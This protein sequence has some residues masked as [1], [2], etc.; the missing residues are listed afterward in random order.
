MNRA[1]VQTQSEVPSPCCRQ[2]KQSIQCDRREEPAWAHRLNGCP[3]SFPMDPTQQQKHRP[4][5]NDQA[6]QS[7]PA[8]RSLFGFHKRHSKSENPNLKVEKTPRGG[9][10]KTRR[11][12]KGKR[13]KGDLA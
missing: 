8:V 6:E 10:G 4:D 12:E 7:R 13:R 5:R 1:A 9:G 3:Q 11:G 2:K